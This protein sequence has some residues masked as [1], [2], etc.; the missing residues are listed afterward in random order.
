MKIIQPFSIINTEDLLAS[1]K[2]LLA[3]NNKAFYANIFP[4]STQIQQISTY[5]KYRIV[6]QI[7]DTFF[8][9]FIILPKHDC[10][11]NTQQ[12]TRKMIKSIE[13]GDFND[14]VKRY[15]NIDKPIDYNKDNDAQAFNN[16]VNYDFDQLQNL[17]VQQNL[18]YN[19]QTNFDEFEP[20]KKPD[21]YAD[22]INH[23]H[24][25]SKK[26]VQQPF[27]YNDKTTLEQI[28][29]WAKEKNILYIYCIIE[30]RPYCISNDYV[31]PYVYYTIKGAY[32]PTAQDILN[33]KLVSGGN[34]NIID[35]IDTD[36]IDE[37]DNDIIW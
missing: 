19:M 8:L 3:K 12:G 31:T 10:I 29:K 21:L 13:I 36:V 1:K 6:T 34:P 7:E 25:N 24:I 17:N 28:F 22:Q 33:M 26:L 15:V 2:I 37:F 32:G 20:Y 4:I 35:E 16:I 14:S 18:V 11:V 30:N 27:K 9:D 5:D 23:P